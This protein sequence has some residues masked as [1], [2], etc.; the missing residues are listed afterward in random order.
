MD[1]SVETGVGV[2]APRQDRSRRTLAR[3]VTA[4]RELLATEGPQALTVQAVVERARASVG[5]FY[6]R[7]TNKEDLLRHL[8]ELV[9]TEAR[10]RWDAAVGPADWEGLPIERRVEA[11]VRL[12]Q[13]A[14]ARGAPERAALA[15]REGALERE[16]AFRRHVRDT[17]QTLLLARR[18]DVRHPD[19]ELAVDLGLRAVTG[20]LRDL[21]EAR[22]AAA[23]PEPDPGPPGASDPSGPERIARE[24]ARLLAAYLTSARDEDAARGR[25]VDFF[26][27]WG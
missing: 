10:E 6:A 9:W 2:R 5:S 26:E 25:D 7:F 11:L 8:E 19:P 16:R 12:L 1:R 20:A 13:E 22:R 18:A 21:E 3:I 15:T 14:G 27:V 24:L 4:A 17:A 23:H